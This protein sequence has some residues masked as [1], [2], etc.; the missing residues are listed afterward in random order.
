MMPLRPYLFGGAAAGALI[1]GVI[2]AFLS[3]TALV[4]QTSFP[5]AT[6]VASPARPETLSIGAGG[7]GAGPRPEDRATDAIAPPPTA[8][9]LPT[10]VASV[11]LAPGVLPPS[12]TPEG[13]DA[14]TRASDGGPSARGAGGG[15]SGS[16]QDKG[17]GGS[18][19]PA[20]PAT[21]SASSAGAPSGT[22]GGTADGKVAAGAHSGGVPPGLAHH[23][24]GLSPGLAKGSGG[25]PP[26]LAKRAGGL[27]PGLAKHGARHASRGR[28]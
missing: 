17:P 18:G 2:A 25:L 20:Q 28:R 7:D 27:P 3:I 5:G 24:G 1:A 23:S 12:T 8:L 4:S 11:G 19:D 26:G 16:H 21:A 15:P 13:Q 10:T 9:G 14:R 6:E 22:G